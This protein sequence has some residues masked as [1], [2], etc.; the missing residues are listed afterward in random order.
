MHKQNKINILKRMV[1]NNLLPERK[2]KTK[3][4]KELPK[5]FTMR[6]VAGGSTELLPQILEKP[7]LTAQ[8]YLTISNS[9]NKSS[10][11]KRLGGPRADVHYG[12]HDFEQKM[13][14]DTSPISSNGQ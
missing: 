2:V 4:N 9:Q 7:S 3:S 11:K 12:L 5:S 1:Q 13:G 10:L 14:K 6:K 8:R